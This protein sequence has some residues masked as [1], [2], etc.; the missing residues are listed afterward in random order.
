MPGEFFVMRALLSVS[1]AIDYALGRIA[2]VFGWLFLVLVAV[3]CWDILTRKIGFQLPR[4]R[5]PPV[6]QT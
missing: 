5:S 1:D 4:L 2:Y 3:I 6:P